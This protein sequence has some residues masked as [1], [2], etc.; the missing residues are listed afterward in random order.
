MG[1][2]LKI[3]TKLLKKSK[4]FGNDQFHHT[5]NKKQTFNC[6]NLLSRNEI[7]ENFHNCQNKKMLRRIKFYFILSNKE[8]DFILVKKVRIYDDM[9]IIK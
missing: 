2:N 5:A 6:R 9:I 4:Y 7:N 3:I 1:Q 8:I